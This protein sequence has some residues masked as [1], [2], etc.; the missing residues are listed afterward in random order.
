[1]PRSLV[2]TSTC[3]LVAACGGLRATSADEGGD[4]TQMDALDC[5]WVESQN[6]WRDAVDATRS[7]VPDED[8]TA[9][10]SADRLSC[11]YDDGSEVT[12]DRP[13]A[14]DPIDTDW[15]FELRTN[16]QSCVSYTDTSVGADAALEVVTSAGLIHME[17]S[18]DDL[19]VTCPDGSAFHTD[20]YVGLYQ[21]CA[22]SEG[23]LPLLTTQSS[24]D[25]F[26][27]QFGDEVDG[28]VTVFWCAP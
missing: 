14:A 15:S 13:V 7:C 12:F 25:R 3:L 26:G 9:T 18:Y 21:S 22:A 28:T 24:P 20:D 6:C 16:G 10:L 27:V 17:G 8:L 11:T 19:T 5:A 4:G 2:L 23:G 1:M